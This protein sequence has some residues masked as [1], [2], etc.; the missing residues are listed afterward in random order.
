MLSLV[1]T[2]LIHFAILLCLPFS[3]SL[4]EQEKLLQ[5]SLLPN[6]CNETC[7]KLHLPFPFYLNNS[8]ES[9]SSSFRLSC[10][11]S[12]TLLLKIGSESYPVRE[13]LPDGVLVDF[14]GTSS[15]RQYNDLNSFGKNF[16]GNDYFGVSLENVIG[17]Y[18]CE[19]SS[20]CKADC[21]TIDLPGCDGSGSGS[22]GC[23]Y[24]LS[25]HSIWHIGE[26]FSV[27][28][29]FGC[30]G[31]SSWAVSRDSISG[32]RGVKLEWAIPRN[33]SKHVCAENADTVNAT[34]IEGGIRCVCQNGY[35]GDGFANGTGCLQ[36][37][38]KNGQEAYGSDCYLKRHDQRKLVII[39]GV[40]GPVLI[41]AS[42]M[43][44]FFLLRKPARPGMFDSEQAYYH[45][46]SF[47]KACRT[48]LFSGHELEEATNGFDEDKKLMHENNGT[49]Y[50][51]VLG[52]GSHVAVH[53]LKCEDEKDLI[54]VLSHIEV[55]SCIVHRN[56]ACLLGCCV[57]SGYTPLVVYE[58]PANGTLEEHLHQ[59]KGLNLSLDWYRRLT[60]A[61]ETAS[62]LAFLQY[63]NTPP[64]FHHNLKSGCIF[65]DDD[66][67]V[68]IAGFGLIKSNSRFGS[69]LY[70]NHEGIHVCKNDVYDVGVV[71][72]EIITGS[73]QLESPSIALQKI[74]AGKLEEI[75]DPLLYYHEQ[76]HYR[77]EQIQ[78]IADLAT[79]CIL[80]GGDGKLAMIDVARELVHITKESL[81]G[82]TMR[83]SALEETFSNSSLLQMISMSPDSVHVPSS[84]LS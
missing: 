24:P 8:C 72:L 66:F 12:S 14:P 63:E 48:R 56:I 28:S 64:I 19:D 15:C 52:D 22:L 60:I 82:E 41:V 34:A 11:N 6:S 69:H 1:F 68:K 47:R 50:A 55:L 40:L 84:F 58:Y 79:R 38:I 74:R 54:Q 59:S 71:L 31:F 73:N 45:N 3:F 17:L 81:H 77:Q 26:G 83:T 20:L 70:N 62:A 42:L 13:F 67:S 29:Q 49:I 43:V 65:L 23:C 32:K 35:V 75:V 18:D 53:Q 78:I 4:Q 51:G 76:P 30:R 7:G 33:S 9:V 44:L 46:T 36:S 61:A 57:D 21:E 2:F 16:A 25:D 10:S 5:P 80:F 39:I 37:C 27:F